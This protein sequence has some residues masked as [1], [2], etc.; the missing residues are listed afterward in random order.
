MTSIYPGLS[1][2]LRVTMI[3]NLIPRQIWTNSH[4]RHH[5]KLVMHGEGGLNKITTPKLHQ[6]VLTYPVQR[7]Q[8]HLRMKTQ[9][10]SNVSITHLKGQQQ[11]QMIVNWEISI[12]TITVFQ[13]FSSR[14]HHLKSSEVS[15]QPTIHQRNHSTFTYFFLSN[16]IIELSLYRI[17]TLYN[18]SAI[19]EQTPTLPL[20]KQLAYNVN[21]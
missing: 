16:F 21:M 17:A 2:L 20:P 7:G 18:T 13:L 8:L 11:P 14:Y 3:K 19:Q 1:T 9:N 6:T 12:R 10:I 4:W 5:W 15:L